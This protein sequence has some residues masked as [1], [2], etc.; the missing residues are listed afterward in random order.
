MSDA[1]LTSRTPDY[2]AENAALALLAAEMAANP[3]GVFQKLA[4]L[5]RELCAAASAGVGIE[6]PGPRDTVIRWLAISGPF[7]AD[8]RV[9]SRLQVLNVPWCAPFNVTG[10]LCAIP[11]SPHQSFDTEHQRLLKSFVPYAAAAWRLRR[12]EIAETGPFQVLFLTPAGVLLDAND[13]FFRETGFTREQVRRREL[14][15]TAMTPPEWQQASN[16]RMALLSTTSHFSPWWVQE[17]LAA[18][19]SRRWMMISGHE[20]GDGS[21][22]QWRIDVT[23]GTNAERARDES[24]K[25]F[26]LFVENVRE[27][28]LIQT[29]PEGRIIGWNPGAERFFGYTESQAMGMQVS[30]LLSPETR[31]TGIFETEMERIGKGLR[32][33]YTRWMQRKDGSRF[34]AHWISEPIRDK[35]GHLVGVARVLRDESNRLRT[36]QSLRAREH[37]FNAIAN[38]VPALLWRTDSAGNANWYNERWFEYTGYLPSKAD[39]FTW[40]E[41]IHPD[42]RNTLLADYLT[43][44][45]HGEFLRKHYRICGTDGTSRWFLVQV[46]SYQH[47]R[48]FPLSWFG[49]ATDVDQERMAVDALKRSLA[50]K[51]ELLKEVHHR[52]KNNLQVITSLLNLQA[53]QIEDAGVLALFDVARNRVQSIASIHELLYRSGSFAAIQLTDYARRLVSDLVRLYGVQNRVEVAVLG[54]AVSLELQRAVPFGLLLNELVSNVCKHAFPPPQTGK[55]TVNLRFNENEIL[56]TVTDNGIGFPP[57]FNYKGATTLGIYLVHRLARQLRAE[58]SFHAD[59]GTTVA[60]RIPASDSADGEDEV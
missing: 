30:L 29:D 6:E 20:L 48:G 25:L 16:D 60:V 23:E 15:W 33:E 53:R 42:D 24:Q 9:N 51:E 35:H 3:G 59:G 45:R 43:A 47:E 12:H 50:E 11:H 17:C 52:V 4:D 31:A 19:G 2:A 38:L 39:R 14:S 32:L 40:L 44:I 26:R 8:G 56:L 28:A 41:V 1:N 13:V 57:G 58:V 7:S 5:T 22:C 36:D 18:D 37:D 46:G 27:Y 10:V 49:A 55:L 21:I 54:E 34:W